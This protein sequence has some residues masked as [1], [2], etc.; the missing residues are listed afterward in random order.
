MA[1]GLPVIACRSGGLPSIVNVD[2]AN[3]TGWLVA[4]DDVDDLAEVLVT[5]VNHPAERERRGANA[6]A[7]AKAELSWDGLVPRF[8]AVYAM[9]IERHRRRELEGSG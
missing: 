1:V 3:P 6:A 4:P 7:H 5:A 8:E 9:G 2:P